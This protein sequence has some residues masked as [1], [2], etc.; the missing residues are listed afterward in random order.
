MRPKILEAIR[1]RYRDGVYHMDPKERQA[2][3]RIKGHEATVI[4][5]D[6]SRLHT[7]VRLFSLDYGR[8]IVP[9]SVMADTGAEVEM[10]V[11]KGIARKLNLTWTPGIQ[12][13]GVGGLGGAEGLADQEIIL[14]IGG[15]GRADDITST[16]FQGSFA[17]KVRPVIMTEELARTIGH[18]ALIGMSVLWRANACIDPYSESMDISPALFEHGCA[19]FKISI[20]CF[21]SKPCETRHPLVGVLGFSQPPRTHNSYLPPVPPGQPKQKPQPKPQ[22]Q[23]AKQPSKVLV[24]G[25]TPLPDTV[26]QVLTR[27]LTNLLPGDKTW[28]AQKITAWDPDTGEIET[29]PLTP[30]ANPNAARAETSSQKPE[31][32]RAAPLHP[33][34]PQS[35]QFPTKQEYRTATEEAALRNAAN[36]ATA[37][38]IREAEIN[39]VRP[40]SYK[41]AAQQPATTQASLQQQLILETSKRQALQ[42]DHEQ[43]LKQLEAD[44]KLLRQALTP[45]RSA[46]LESVRQPVR[47]IKPPLNQ[48]RPAAPK[49]GDNPSG[50]ASVSAPSVPDTVPNPPP[51]GDTKGKGRKTLPAE[52]PSTHNM[53]TR[54]QVQHA[55]NQAPEPATVAAVPKAY[56]PRPVVPDYWEDS[57]LGSGWTTV[58]RKNQRSNPKVT[59]VAVSTAVVAAAGAMLPT[60]QAYPT[61]QVAAS[62]DE[63]HWFWAQ[64]AAIVAIWACFVLARHLARGNHQH[65]RTINR[66][67]GSAVAVWTTQVT[68]WTLS[69]ATLWNIAVRTDIAPFLATATIALCSFFAYLWRRAER[70]LFNRALKS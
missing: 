18:S 62:I 23:Q 19:G 17:I 13:A 25:S 36:R 48:T 47:D 12:L 6:Q 1:N 32:Q 44:M 26:S 10:C 3:D 46:P 37:H 43:R 52:R 5:I 65:T 45:A 20:P 15:D 27:A 63:P 14:R 57:R 56:H 16:P 58:T 41:E 30:K 8:G 50:G 68:G 21:M 55:A 9:A 22:K 28:A 29:T 69:V 2:H 38:S 59:A 7:A 49:L 31:A 42:A 33:G 11:S 67:A 40:R 34:F 35:G 53:S 24:A 64:V 61:D 54:R 70:K 4:S 39:R 51:A 60:A 66:L